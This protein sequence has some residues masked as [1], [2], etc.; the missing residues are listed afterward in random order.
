MFRIS[1]RSQRMSTPASIRLWFLMI[2]REVHRH[3]VFASSLSISPVIL[4]LCIACGPELSLDLDLDADHYIRVRCEDA[5]ARFD[6]CAPIPE[7]WGD[8]SVSDCIES[9]YT[10][11]DD[12]CFAHEDEFSRCRI[13]RLSCDERFNVE[14]DLGTSPGSA[15]FEFLVVFSERCSRIPKSTRSSYAKRTLCMYAP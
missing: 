2:V 5:C 14:G 8:C 15:C 10:S 6:E 7:I 3:Q 11:L 12:P 9:P 4:P 13:E 1:R